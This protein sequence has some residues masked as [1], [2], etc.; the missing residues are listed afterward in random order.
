M[1]V[2]TEAKKMVGVISGS[3]TKK[4]VCSRLAPSTR[5]ASVISAGTV[6]S[7]ASMIKKV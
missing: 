4:N 7:P 5:A 1:K 3:V 2:I 6:C